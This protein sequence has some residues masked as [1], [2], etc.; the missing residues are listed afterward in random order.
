MKRLLF[1]LMIILGMTTTVAFGQKKE[2]R[3]VSGFTG[4]DASSMFDI[5]VSKGDKESLVIEADDEVM[6]YVRSE[7]KN[8]V[9]NLYLDNY[10]TEN[11]KKVYILRAVIVMK[12]LDKVSLSG[13]CKLTTTDLF[14][15]DKFKVD[16]SGATSM[17][18]NVSTNQ[19]NIE[20]SGVC[21]IQIKAAVAGDTKMDISDASKISGELQTANVVFS[22]SGVSA[23][24]LTGSAT[25]IKMKVAG[26]SKV[27]AENFTVKN[28]DIVSSGTSIIKVNATDALK[29][30]SSGAAS[31]NYKGSPAVQI[32]SSE[33]ARVTKI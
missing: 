2:T 11:N 1:F 12:N 6:P 4:I 30:S 15:P 14:S 33:A 9:L 13:V 20:T 22:S 10:K 18:V 23:V 3:P 5:T 17:T 21:N 7:V 28:A 26:T 24:E 16:C 8:G 32:N 19:L 27:I 29:V 25:S 31:V